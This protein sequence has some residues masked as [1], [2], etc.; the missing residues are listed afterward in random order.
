[1]RT[2][3]NGLSL[4]LF[5][6]LAS[7]LIFPEVFYAYTSCGSLS[8]IWPNWNTQNVALLW[9]P[10]HTLG[11]A[12]VPNICASHSFSSEERGLRWYTLCMH[13]VWASCWVD[14]PD[15]VQEIYLMGHR[16]HMFPCLHESGVQRAV[17][18]LPNLTVHFLYCLT[19]EKVQTPR[20]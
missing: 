6:A 18:G 13:S 20:H 17:H 15:L 7:L 9:V 12:I 3:F 4:Y 10:T 8:S 1:M 11:E 16:N 19:M 5:L 2:V 14:L